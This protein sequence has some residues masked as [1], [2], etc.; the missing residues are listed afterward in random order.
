MVACSWGGD[1]TTSMPGD[2]ERIYAEYEI[3]RLQLRLGHQEEFCLGSSNKVSNHLRLKHLQRGVVDDLEFVTFKG[4]TCVG[5]KQV[6]VVRVFLVIGEDKA[7]TH[8][9]RDELVA[10]AEKMPRT[11]TAAT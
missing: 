11:N 10:T 1:T 9:Q 7:R 2:D 5:S 6:L 8:F 4:A 3:C